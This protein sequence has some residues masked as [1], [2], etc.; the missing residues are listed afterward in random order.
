MPHSPA[1]APMLSEA[2]RA[3]LTSAMAA[4]HRHEAEE[5]QAQLIGDMK[6]KGLKGA[7]RPLSLGATAPPSGVKGAAHQGG[8]D[9]KAG[10]PGS[11]AAAGGEQQPGRPPRRTLAEDWASLLLALRA[12]VVWS[13]AVW[14]MFY[15]TC[16]NGWVGDG[17]D[18][19]ARPACASC[20][21]ANRAGCYAFNGSLTSP[22]LCAQ[23]PGRHF[24]CAQPTHAGSHS[25]RP[26]SSSPCWA[27]R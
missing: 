6:A 13:G 17:M 4:A 21:A 26:S 1:T 20:W 23:P 5:Q 22:F 3:A 27:S 15:C 18:G 7:L 25:S 12:P 10:R 9:L 8:S 11:P 2:E 14:R 24:F 19:W 16:L